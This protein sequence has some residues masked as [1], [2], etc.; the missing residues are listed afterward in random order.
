MSKHSFLGWAA[1][2][3]I[4]FSTAAFLYSPNISAEERDFQC[5]SEQRIKEAVEA[6]PRHLKKIRENTYLVMPGDIFT[7]GPL[8]VHTLGDSGISIV[9]KASPYLRDRYAVHNFDSSDIG[10]ATTAN[11]I[12]SSNEE[13]LPD[14]QERFVRTFRI[15][16]R[17]LEISA[18]TPHKRFF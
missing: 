1:A 10:C 15:V 13:S 14:A 7:R 4:P 12:H 3:L 9:D 18:Q 5:I 16:E 8:E 17:V 2:G 11:S 6:V